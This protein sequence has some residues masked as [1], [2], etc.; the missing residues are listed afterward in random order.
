M[1]HHRGGVAGGVVG[2]IANVTTQYFYYWYFHFDSFAS[3]VYLGPGV[4]LIIDTVEGLMTGS[5]LGS[6]AWVVFWL[7]A[8]APRS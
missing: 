7:G 1:E 8:N 4:C 5:L 6:V 3:V 2:A